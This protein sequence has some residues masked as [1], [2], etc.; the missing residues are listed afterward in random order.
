MKQLFAICTPSNSS[1]DSAVKLSTVTSVI[2]FFKLTQVRV[3][4]HI[5]SL[6]LNCNVRY[7]LYNGKD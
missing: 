1:L 4:G 7:L 6:S 5:N 2:F 3:Q